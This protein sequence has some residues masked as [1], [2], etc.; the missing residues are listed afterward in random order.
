MNT[1]ELKNHIIKQIDSL[2]EAEF[3]KVYNQLINIL[4]SANCYQLSEEE[5]EAIESA[6]K[7]SEEGETY[8][9]DQ[10]QNEAGDK[11][12]NLKFK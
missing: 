5:N 4:Q 8:S 6:L 9:H 1:L 7:V 11:F 2:N 10:V 12:P 3:D